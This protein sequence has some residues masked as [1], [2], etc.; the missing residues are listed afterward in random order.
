M[1]GAGHGAVVVGPRRQPRPRRLRRPTRACSRRRSTCSPT[2]ASSRTRS[3]PASSPATASTDTTRPE[4]ADRLAPA[5]APSVESGQPIDDHRHRH[6]RRAAA[7]SAAS[8]SRSTAATPGTRRTGARTGA[9]PGRRARPAAPRSRRAPPTTAATSRAPAPGV[10]VDVVPRDLPVLDLGRLGH[11]GADRRT[12]PARS[13][14]GV[15]FRSDEA[16]FITG[17][18]FYKGA[19]NTGT[20]VGH[21]WT[22]DGTHARRGDLHRRERVGLA[23]GELRR[24]RCAIDRGHDLRRLLPRAERATTRPPTATSRPTASTTRRC[25]RSPTATTG[26]TASTDYGAGGVFPTET[27]KASNYWVD[28]V[29]DD[30]RRA[31]RRPRP[32]INARSPANGASGRRHR[33]RT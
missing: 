7:R 33:R 14:S 27:F 5:T 30:R 29:F 20:H 25:T 3:R 2:W 12:T 26:R 8:R 28:V 13:S 21:L 22:A 23:G 24:R 17:L 1:F 11:A 9:T 16:G 31:G 15:K 6:R 4:L 19:L 32:T 18:R 10:T